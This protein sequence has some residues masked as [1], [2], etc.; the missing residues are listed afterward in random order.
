[1]VR[2]VGMEGSRQIEFVL[3]GR[4]DGVEITPDTIGLSRFNEFNRQVEE[5]I[6][7]SDRLLLDQVKARVEPGSYKLVTWLPDVV[8]SS[9]EPDLKALDRQDSLG[10]LDPKRAEVIARWQARA[11]SK[12]ELSYAIRPLDE[13]LHPVEVS[14]RSDF[15]VGDVVPWVKVEKYLFGTVMDMGGAKKANVHIR[16]D[17]GGKLVKIGSDQ[18]YL[19]DQEENHLYRKVLARVEARQHF[20]TGELKDFRLLSFEDYRPGY[21]EDVLDRF[22]AA[23][24]ASWADVPDAS[25]WVERLRGGGG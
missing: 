8:F 19:H 21:D 16:L 25:G 23:G 22:A 2:P 17:D 1:M 18:E 3:R 9:L 24:R 10:E 7:G 4:L 5:F 14:S 11:K 13:T 12:P 15:R 20:R 6:G